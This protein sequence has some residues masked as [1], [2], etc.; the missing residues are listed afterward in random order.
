MEFSHIPVLYKEVMEGMA[1]RAD[2]AYIDGTVGG[3]GHSSGIAESL[4]DGGRLYCFDQDTEALA[5]AGKRLE[6]FGSRVHFYHDNYVNAV[7]DLKADGVTGVDGI[8]LDIGVSSYQLDNPERGFSYNEDAPLDMRM[9]RENP[10][11]AYEIVND[12]EEKELARILKEY[13]EEKFAGRIAKNIVSERAKAPI[14]TTFELNEIIKMSIP[15]KMRAYGHPSKRTYQA[16]RVEC[17][18][19]LDV[20]KESI[21]GMIDFLNPGG[22]LLIISFQSL[23]DRIVKNAF[24]TAENPCICPPSLPQCVCGRKSKGKVIT[25]HPITASAEEAEENRR[26]KPA[27]LRIFEKGEA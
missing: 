10:L 27:K 5:A 22:R 17:N 24:R 20:L 3:G 2:G 12:Y 14:R 1:V 6:K 21:D 25:R 19:E 7:K 16:L 26:S 15:A 18:R 9:N 4:G 23:E 11:S 8:L 13:G